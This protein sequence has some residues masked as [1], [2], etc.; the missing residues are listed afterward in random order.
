MIA[1]FSCEPSLVTKEKTCNRCNVVLPIGDFN[2]W[3]RGDGKIVVKGFCAKCVREAAAE[4]RRNNRDEVNRKSREYYRKMTPEQI[5]QKRL[6]GRKNPS[7]KA[8]MAEYRK[9][10]REKV[11]GWVRKYQEKKKQDPNWKKNLA[12]Q[13]KKRRTEDINHKIKHYC[14]VRVRSALIRKS[15]KKTLSLNELTGCQNS[16]LSFYVFRGREYKP[17]FHIDHY[18]P[19][20]YFDLTN[21]SEQRVCFNWRNL[22]I[23]TA[24]ENL[25]KNAK[26]PDDYRERE[27]EIRSALSLDSA[28]I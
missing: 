18:I 5:A 26:L 9:K 20:D 24:S 6:N 13:A 21:E 8:Y 23:I 11:L 3:R 12:A 28:Q 4:K 2:H 14:R 19:C 1:I 15:K 27:L 25:N 16:L 17:G 22:H 10:N 7:T